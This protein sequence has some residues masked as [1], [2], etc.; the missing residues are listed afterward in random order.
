[1]TYGVESLY[2]E[3]L[4]DRGTVLLPYISKHGPLQWEQAWQLDSKSP[5]F[6]PSKWLVWRLLRTEEADPFILVADDLP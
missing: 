1:M 5:C 2:V 4:S 3:P 6:Y